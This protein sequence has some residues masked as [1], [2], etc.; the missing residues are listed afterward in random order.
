MRKAVGNGLRVL[1]RLEARQAGAR[2]KA[3]SRR[4][5]L[6]RG[7]LWNFRSNGFSI[8]SKPAQIDQ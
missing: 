5:S 3:Q 4:V 1:G 6:E 2:Y 7:F 8:G